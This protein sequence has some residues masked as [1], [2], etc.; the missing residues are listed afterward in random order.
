MAKRENAPENASS[1]DMSGSSSQEST[2]PAAPRLSVQLDAQ[3]AIDFERMRPDTREKLRAALERSGPGAFGLRATASAVSGPVVESFP[4]EMAE[5]IYD[6][7]SSLLVGLARR[8][9]HSAESAGV[10]A[11]TPQE[12]QA[13][14]PPT[15]AVL[16]K[17]NAS[18]GKYQEEITLGIL[19]VTIT[20]GKL[21]LLRK[22]AQVINL[23]PRST[24]EP[25]SQAEI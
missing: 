23:T 20:S 11:F 5:V 8:G 1:S 10:L 4:P 14:V 16:N 2:A 13:L 9:G 24:S 22:S 12:K 19:L 18:L 3:G 21:A 25:A 7:L 6:S 17:Y 15:V